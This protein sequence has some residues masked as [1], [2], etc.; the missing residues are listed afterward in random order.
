MQ[1]STITLL[2]SL[3]LFAGCGSSN[4]LVYP[5]TGLVTFNDQPLP[6]GTVVFVPKA[7]GP[8]A[9][10]EIGADGRYTLTTFTA[11]DGALPGAYTVLVSAMQDNGPNAPASAL[12]PDRF[13]SEKSG[14]TGE[15]R[16]V[17]QNVIDL[18]LKGKAA[19]K[20]T[21]PMP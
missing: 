15:V 20:P 5:V 17:E 11:G 18:A 2:A 14:L 1:K 9:Q 6:T 10:G 8:P 16:E 19:A 13:A 21:A 4:P 12:V 7:G 3:A